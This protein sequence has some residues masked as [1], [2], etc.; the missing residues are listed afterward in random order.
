MHAKE[1][2]RY[3]F[4]EIHHVRDRGNNVE[5][6][7]GEHNSIYMGSFDLSSEGIHSL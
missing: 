4:Q 2:L 7:N 6:G 3:I 5:M 1:F